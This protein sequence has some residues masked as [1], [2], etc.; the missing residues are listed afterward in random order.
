MNDNSIL[1]TA[2]KASLVR[3]GTKQAVHVPDGKCEPILCIHEVMFDVML[4]QKIKIGITRK[5]HSSMNN[6]VAPFIPQSSCTVRHRRR[7]SQRQRQQVVQRTKGN[8]QPAAHEWSSINGYMIVVLVMMPLMNVLAHPIKGTV[9]Q[10]LV[11]KVFL[12]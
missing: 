11:Q 7:Q 2:T 12:Q 1:V 6:E 10:V 5:S 9:Q 4:L 8:E 3:I